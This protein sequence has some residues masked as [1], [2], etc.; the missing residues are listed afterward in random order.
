MQ[1]SKACYILSCSTEE[2]YQTMSKSNLRVAVRLVLL[3]SLIF[4]LSL[5]QA[6]ADTI[7]SSTA[8]RN[9]L[10]V[11]AGQVYIYAG[12]DFASSGETV[13]TFSWYGPVF[14]G[15]RNLTPLLFEN[16][17]DGS[18][19]VEA[20]GTAISVSG[21]GSVQGPVSFGLQAGSLITGSN[22]TFGFV[23]GLA[24]STGIVGSPTAG[25]VGFD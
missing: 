19:T 24:G 12:G 3:F 15:S 25:V 23:T 14:S 10:D 11:S 9:I 18:Y 1:W 7:G 8:T 5:T 17:G 20:I 13:S 4:A 21:T 22:E 2:S 6:W 16:N